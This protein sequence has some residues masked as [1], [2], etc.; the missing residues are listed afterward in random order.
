M[1]IMSVLNKHAPVIF[2]LFYCLI[3]ASC[4]KELSLVVQIEDNNEFY[5]SVTPEMEQKLYTSVG[6]QY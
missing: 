1:F 5:F 6:E 3:I 4:Y 2:A